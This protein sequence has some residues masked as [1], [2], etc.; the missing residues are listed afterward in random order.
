MR[1]IV[2]GCDNAAVELKDLIKNHLQEKGVKVEDVGAM[3]SEDTTYY[4]LVAEKV[5]EK[6]QESNFE[7][8]GILICG[9]GI[10]MAITANKC[11]GIRAAVC[12]EN[13]SAERSV[14]SNNG[15]VLCMGARIIGP[16]LAKKIVDEWITLEFVDGSSTPK[17][18]AM[19]DIEDKNFK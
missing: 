3:T 8:R 15:N 10:G 2:I 17:V 19:N 16:E 5:A 9:T 1:D 13:Y 14:L 12:H 11:K 7:K 6:V 18:E 4:P